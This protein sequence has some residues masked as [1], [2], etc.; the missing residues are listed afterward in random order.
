MCGIGGIWLHAPDERLSPALG[1]MKVALRHRGPDGEGIWPGDDGRLGLAHTRL[2]IVDLSPAGAQPMTH[3]RFTAVFNGE[4]YNWRDLRRELE[5]HGH[6]FRTQSDTEVLLAGF[7]QWGEGV[8]AR[9]RGMFAFAIWDE[10]ARALFCARDP[11]GKK[12]FVYAEGARGFAFG[13]EIPAVKAAADLAGIDLA[14]DPS[15]IAAML[16][17]NLR[18]IPDP[19]TVFRGVRRLRAGHAMRVEN[20]RVARTWRYWNPMQRPDIAGRVSAADIRAALEEA[21]ALRRIADVPVGALLSGGVDSSAIVA[22]A[23]RQA[24]EPVR[25]YAMGLDRDDEDL[26]RARVMAKDIGTVHR[27]FYFDPARQWEVFNAILRTHGEPI[28]LFPLI[29]TFELCEAVRADGIKVVL[30]GNGAD[31]LFYGYTGMVQ[32]SRLSRGIKLLE[33]AAPL[34]R[35][36]PLARMPRAVEAIAAPRGRR[37]AALYRRYARQTWPSLIAPD[38]LGDLVNHAERELADWGEAGPNADYVDESNFGGLMVENT[39]SVTIAA[40]LPAMMAG[41]EMRAPFLDRDLMALALHTPWQD[42]IVT[43]GEGNRLKYILKQAVQ[44]LMPP[45][46]LYASKRGFGMGI[47]QDDVVRGPWRKQADDLFASPDTAGGLLSRHGLQ[48]MWRRFCNGEY[49]GASLPTNVFAIQL[50][51]QRAKGTA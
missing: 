7:A 31:E 16:L 18:H 43:S 49:N 10:Q 24:G 45:D 19:A 5:A 14:L 28:M 6:V 38:A 17:H 15:A 46:I 23:Q 21:V 47:A 9:L 35:L 2:A 37:K 33:W 11:V 4:I 22:L 39:H 36:L 13:S 3:G 41:V 51:L 34:L 8:V 29:H 50:W 32:T 26:R 1:A 30:A 20:G 25:T 48:D 12:P 40:D 42:K 27:E 44:D